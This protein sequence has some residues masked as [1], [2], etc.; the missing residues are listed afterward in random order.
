MSL[1]G[2]KELVIGIASAQSIAYGCAQALRA[3]G[4]VLVMTSGGY[5]AGIVGEPGQPRRHFRYRVADM[6]AGYIDLESWVA[7]TATSEGS[8]WPVRLQC[9]CSL[10]SGQVPPPLIG[11][12]DY[13]PRD[14]IPGNY[15]LER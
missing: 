6:H 7:A 4:T 13:P 2:K 11:T 5:N 1:K 10:T 9:L 15:V 8:W 12:S 3:A 14:S